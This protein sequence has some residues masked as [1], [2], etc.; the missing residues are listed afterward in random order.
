MSVRI[1]HLSKKIGMDNSE[2]IQLLRERGHE[3]K[4][5]SS[6]VDN[7]SADALREEFGSRGSAEEAPSDSDKAEATEP[8]K[9]EDGLPSG[10]I[11]R[12]REEIE[13]EREEREREEA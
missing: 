8:Q 4:S 6:T 3:A 7:I 12:S 9:E 10:A 5:A 2:L 11:V 13:R 1:Y